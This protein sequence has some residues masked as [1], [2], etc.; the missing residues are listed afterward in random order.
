ML[1][2]P[3]Q[4]QSSVVHIIGGKPS[5][6]EDMYAT[7][8]RS[9][10]RW[11]I[12]FGFSIYLI[13][14]AIFATLYWLIPDGIQGSRGT[15]KEAF[16]FSVQTISTIGYG[17]MSPKGLWANLLVTFE[18]L[19]G[20]ITTAM[21]TGLI[22]TKFA[23][24]TARVS[25]TRHAVVQARDGVPCL[26]FRVAN[27]RG[28]NIIEASITA[29]VLLEEVTQEGERMR[30]LYDLNLLRHNTPIFLLSWTVIHPIDEQSPLYGIDFRSYRGD[31]RIFI[32]LTGLDGVFSQTVHAHHVYYANQILWNQRF[33]DVIEH[34]DDNSV[35]L[36]LRHFQDTEPVSGLLLPSHIE[37][38]RKKSS[39]PK[40]TPAPSLHVSLSS[41]ERI[42][43][44]KQE[45]NPED[46]P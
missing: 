33:L 7:L 38:E 17:T 9:P 34:L 6:L 32:S 18:S 1:L 42:R 29:T 41:F 36:D 13:L 25:F 22:F 11:L 8:L 14:N 12:L 3:P 30:R 10:W 45:S 35:R 16:F 40:D 26:M 2:P 44:K 46:E 5:F 21:I 4:D 24:P 37:D 39:P 19:I 28:A 27:R 23:R 43:P 31:L 20:I 15:W